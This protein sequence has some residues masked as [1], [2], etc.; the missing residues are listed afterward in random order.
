MSIDCNSPDWPWKKPHGVSPSMGPFAHGSDI[1]VPETPNNQQTEGKTMF[2]GLYESPS[3]DGSHLVDMEGD[4]LKTL[5]NCQGHY[6]C[7][8][9]PLCGMPI[10]P[11]VGYTAEYEPG[12]KWVGLEYFNFSMAD[13][14]PTVLGAFVEVVFDSLKDKGLVPDLI[15]GAPWAGVK[16]SHVASVYFG[17][18]H[19]FAEKKGDDL[20]LGRYEG[21][22]R[23]GDK[24]V[25]GE[26][27][28]NNAST[29][30]KLINL[31]EDAGGEVIAIIAAINRSYPFRD[32]FE[33]PD[34]EPIPIISAI[35]RSTPQYRQDDPMVTEAIAE[36]N[37]V[38]KP[39][40]EWGRMKTAMEAARK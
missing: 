16:F 14:W 1:V 32:A 12:K 24:V 26:E 35:E 6:A 13:Q 18:R 7:P 15:V 34:R 27:L 36:G 4:L 5:E 11:I 21:A 9:S 29:T 10:G 30:G 3:P 40:Y 38:W 22:I 25:I 2:E 17:C 39:K 8:V 33:I 28:V 20:I 19:I 23:R 37:V 31:I